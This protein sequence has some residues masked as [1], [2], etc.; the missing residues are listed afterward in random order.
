MPPVEWLLDNWTVPG[1]YAGL[2]KRSAPCDMVLSAMAVH[3][4]QS[5][6]LMLDWSFCYAIYKL[7]GQSRPCLPQRRALPNSK[8]NLLGWLVLCHGIHS[9]VDLKQVEIGLACSPCRS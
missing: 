4:L 3:G 6:E 7:P 8:P 2:C 1:F 9:K 5:N